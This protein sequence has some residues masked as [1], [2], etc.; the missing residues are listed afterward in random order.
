M[1]IID[2]VEETKISDITLKAYEEKS[3]TILDAH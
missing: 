2:L 3:L 1:H